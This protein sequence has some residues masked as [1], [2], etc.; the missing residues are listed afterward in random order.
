MVGSDTYAILSGYSGGFLGFMENP[1]FFL[2]RRREF[3]G[4]SKKPEGKEHLPYVT[5]VYFQGLPFRSTHV[6]S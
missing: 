3:N 4:V 1:E 5:G 2:V 6:F